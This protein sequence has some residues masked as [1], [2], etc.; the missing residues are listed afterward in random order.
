MEIDLA[1]LKKNNLSPNEFV[2]L[3]LL[4]LGSE[5]DGIKLEITED[6]KMELARRGFL[7]STLDEVTQSFREEFST[8]KESDE[9]R[10]EEFCRSY[11][12][13]VPGPQGK[14]I[15]KAANPDAKTNEKSKKKYLKYIKGKPQLHRSAVEAIAVMLR[16]ENLKYLQK[17]DTFVNQYSWEKYF[18][19]VNQNNSGS[20]TSNKSNYGSTLI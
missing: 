2:F 13:T 20:S 9:K 1:Y 11:P 15:L 14:R 8:T 18:D 5:N 4:R 10:W 7:E 17:F 19:I 16:V 12:N 6:Q 3:E